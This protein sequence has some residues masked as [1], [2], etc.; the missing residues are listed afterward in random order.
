M[1]NLIIESGD[2]LYIRGF[3]NKEGFGS[4][5]SDYY[6]F[7]IE[8]NNVSCSGNIMSLIDYKKSID[9][10]PTGFCFYKLFDGCTALTTAPELPATKLKQ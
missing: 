6:T 4:S 10:I 3:L 7:K 8:G 2:I 9:T 5:D 1:K